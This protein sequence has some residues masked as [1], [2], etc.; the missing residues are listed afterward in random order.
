MRVLYCPQSSVKF[1]LTRGRTILET[2]GKDV[3]LI[4]NM[5]IQGYYG[6]TENA[7]LFLNELLLHQQFY[8]WYVLTDD[9]VYVWTKRLEAELAKIDPQRLTCY[10]WIYEFTQNINRDKWSE[11]KGEGI[12]TPIKYPSGPCFAITN[13]AFQKMAKFLTLT[14]QTKLPYSYYA[15]VAYGFYM[16]ACGIELVHDD[17]FDIEGTKTD[18]E[19]LKT[20]LMSHRLSCDKI[21]EIHAGR[22]LREDF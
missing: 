18:A 7:K 6:S 12:Q 5:N 2:W 14:D 10:C 11:C 8:D 17:R 13:A 4:P 22:N 3:D 1:W 20:N 21:R 16:R 9:D 15:D 19:H